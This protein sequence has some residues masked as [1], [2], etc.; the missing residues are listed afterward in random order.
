MSR[1]T[2][3]AVLP[4]LILSGCGD[5]EP[6][7]AAPGTGTG[8]VISDDVVSH[9]HGI[10]V[11]PADDALIVATHSGLF[12]AA[13]GQRRAERLSELRQD[14]MGFTVL[15][16]DRFLG[17]GHPAVGAGQPANLGLIESND[18]GKSWRSLSL[19]GKADF[20]V[21]RASGRRI[22]GVNSSDGALLVSSDGGKRWRRSAPPGTV[23][24]LAID[25]RDP[26]HVMVSGDEGLARSK[27][28]GRTWTKVRGDLVGLLAWGPRLVLVDANGR[29]YASPDGGRRFTAVGD[30]GGQPAA[31]AAA[32]GQLLVALHDNS[33]RSSDDGGRTWQLR[34]D[35]Q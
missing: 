3:L 21:L 2:L 32:D 19:S 20:H 5:R 11:N 18:A 34:L 12:R 28:A 8:L 25:P 26:N 24:D 4:L 22:Y 1:R 6:G 9:I 35:G 31:A 29:V 33:V 15:G 16:A 14:T 30:V 10:G 7:A 13:P 17:S 23:G 27:D